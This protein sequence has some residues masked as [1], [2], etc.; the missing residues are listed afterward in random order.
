MP[1]AHTY[2]APE[3]AIAALDRQRKMKLTMVVVGL[4]AALVTLVGASALMYS[5]DDA[6][7]PAPQQNAP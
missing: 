7:Q 6:Y 5:D 4:V 3:M 2:D 1:L